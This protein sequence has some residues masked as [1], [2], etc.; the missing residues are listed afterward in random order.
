MKIPAKVID[1]SG[2]ADKG[3]TV[4]LA[5]DKADAAPLPYNEHL[6]PRAYVPIEL[7]INGMVYQARLFARPKV[8]YV[9]ISTAL[10]RNGVKFSL[11]DV[12]RQVSILPN[13]RVTIEVNRIE[14]AVERQDRPRWVCILEL[15][16]RRSKGD[17]TQRN[18]QV[19]TGDTDSRAVIDIGRAA[20]FEKCPAWEE[21]AQAVREYNSKYGKEDASLW[22]AVV[23]A[24]GCLSQPS[25]NSRLEGFVWDVKKWGR[26]QGVS[27]SD[28]PAAA[29]ALWALRNQIQALKGRSFRD[30]EPQ[31]VVALLEKLVRAMQRERIRREEFSWGSKILHWLLPGSVPVYDSVVRDGFCLQTTGIHAYSF[32][33]K[34]EYDCAARLEP[35]REKLF[36]HIEPRTLLRCIDKYLWWINVK[37]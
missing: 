37:R 25:Y 2:A 9:W 18:A 28:R 34:W 3:R 30:V 19:R 16:E 8:P 29:K 7:S 15:G 4:C 14:P 11:A 1:Y 26:I 12:L 33:V 24:A 17:S 20:E 32:I 22:V 13:D 23:G 10:E 31:A 27:L 35:H 6:P 21:V 36:G 5:V